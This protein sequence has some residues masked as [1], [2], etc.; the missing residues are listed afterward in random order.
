M[1]KAEKISHLLRGKIKELKIRYFTELK[2]ENYL[3]FRDKSKK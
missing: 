3:F 2:N 1:E